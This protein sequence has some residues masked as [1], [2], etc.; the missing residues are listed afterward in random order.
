MPMQLDFTRPWRI[1]ET[2]AGETKGQRG[3][4]PPPEETDDPA[5]Y[6]AA[7]LSA[8]LGRMTGK[9]PERGDGG[10]QGDIIVLHRGGETG[11]PERGAARAP[12]GFSWRAAPDRVE[13]YGD[14]G[15]GLLRAAYDFLGALGARW[16]AP[17]PDGERLARGPAFE[18]AAPAGRSL[19]ARPSTTL[20]LGH[21]AYLERY[22][23]YL[24][25]AA[26]V[27]YSSVSI[28]TTPEA[29]ALDAAPASLY[30]AL[31]G[32]IGALARRLG[33]S[34]ELGGPYLSLEPEAFAAF[35]ADHPEVE[36]FHAWPGDPTEGRLPSRA[37][38][39]PVP[40]AVRSL[41]TARTLAAALARARPGARLSLPVD[42]DAGSVAEALG[43]AG[44]PG[45][46]AGPLPP[47]LELLWAPRQRSWGS[48]LC[49]SASPLNA[50]SLAA[51]REAAAAWRAAGGGGICVLER[52]EDAFLFKGAAPPLASVLEGDLAAYGG[53]APAGRADS[54]G[55]LCAGGRLP[56]APRPN[57]ALLP[58]LAST[59][60]DSKAALADWAAAAYGADAEPMLEYWGELE[61][62]WAIDL[63]VREG[64][65]ALRMP[66]LLSRAAYDPPADW[67]DPW[68]AGAE[69]LAAKRARCEELFDRLRGAEAALS[70]AMLSEAEGS[71]GEARAIRGEA[72][73]Y[74]ISGSVLELDCAR[75]SAYH[76][77]ASGDP[78]AAA[79]IANLALSAAAAVVA[80]LSSLPDRRARRETALLIE[81][82]YG[83][84]LRAIRRANARSGLRR[85]VDLRAAAAR[86]SLAASR[87]AGAYAPAPPRAPARALAPPPRRQ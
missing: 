70:R 73:E 18:L 39:A 72:D 42:R 15:R 86:A 17:G 31:R 63:D 26:R 37:Y 53:G 47:G 23:D 13:I 48:A 11:S 20:V 69:R 60:I 78:R 43:P 62:A 45:R 6:A 50:A 40:S 58:R 65:C 76:E 34:L 9:A 74:A 41:E 57:A 85:I 28:R 46:G 3:A 12:A 61:A 79:D 82:F 4:F 24:P 22:A 81:L 66:E 80:A 64:D 67:G 21:G 30:E 75:L 14:D 1:I 87:V 77:L 29:L 16:V 8:V 44:S 59:G 25:W 56:L 52:W 54:L 10:E 71:A 19:P 38:G 33:L 35:A 84:R 51:F 36:V 55:I 7:E 2:R 49:D 5:S 83:L 68:T 27:G 32:D